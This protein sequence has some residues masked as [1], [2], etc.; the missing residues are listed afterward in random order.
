[1]AMAASLLDGSWNAAWDARPARWLQGRHSVWLLFGVR[2]CLSVG[3]TP[4]VRPKALAHHHIGGILTDSI[5]HVQSGLDSLDAVTLKSLHGKQV[6][7]D[8]SV[9]GKS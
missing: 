9:T 4:S 3:P 1:M 8:Y 5:T 6:Y 2:T 7:T